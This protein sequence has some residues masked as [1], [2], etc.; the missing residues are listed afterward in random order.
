M[1]LFVRDK[2]ASVTRPVLELR[3]FAKVM[4]RAGESGTVR[5]TLSATICGFWARLQPVF[6]AGEVELLAGPC[7]DRTK[8]LS[9]TI[10]LR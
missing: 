1:F 7:A 2:V 9:T 5:L 10:Q 6:E 8:L 4:L 3:G